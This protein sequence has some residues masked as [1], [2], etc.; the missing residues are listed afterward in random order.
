MERGRKKEEKELNKEKKGEREEK[1]W[2][3]TFV[4]LMFFFA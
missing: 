3:K 2:K 1:K 4:F